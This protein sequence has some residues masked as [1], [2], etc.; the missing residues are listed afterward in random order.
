MNWLYFSL[1]CLCFW[2]PTGIFLGKANGMH[3]FVM[4][5]HVQ[6]CALVVFSIVLQFLQP[7]DLALVTK[8]SMAFSVANG[9]CT[10]FAYVF[11]LKSFEA[12]PGKVPEI[13]LVTA[14]YPITCVFLIWGIQNVRPTWVDEIVKIKFNHLLSAVLFASAFASWFWQPEWTE[15]I[16]SL[17]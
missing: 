10:G 2:T 4:T 3:G 8:P 6:A 13:E 11:F 9:I 7:P 5:F 15:K 1:A 16:K 17:L 12:A 14:L